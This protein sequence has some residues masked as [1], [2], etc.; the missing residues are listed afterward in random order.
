LAC[1][2]VISYEVVTACGKV[3]NVSATSYPDLFWAL[4][5]GGNNFGIV[6]KFTV[7]AIQKSPLMW[8]GTRLYA[9]P[10]FSALLKAFYNL[11]HNV[12]KD[13]KAHQILS[14]G[15][16]GPQIGYAA[17]VELEYADPNGNAAVLAEYNAIGSQG[18]LQGQT[19]NATLLQ[20]TSAL[21]QSSG[22]NGA[23]QSFITW[24]VGLDLNLANITM[25]ILFEEIPSVINAT[26]ILP[27]LSFQVISEP[28]IQQTFK[29]GG[30]PLG[31]DPKEGPLM[32]VLLN[33][34]WTDIRDDERI[35]AFEMRVKRR[36]EAAALAAGKATD[37]IYMNY[38]NPSQ[39]VISG[40]GATNKAK[41]L[42][43]AKKYDP[44]GVFQKLQPG[45][46][47]LEGAPNDNIKQIN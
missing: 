22:G 33:T 45:Y 19:G 38:G 12:A 39:D 15:Y 1:D 42:A 4:R 5:G 40:Y 36:S 14:F 3:I 13:G 10:A 2:N 31:L 8:G 18:M 34:K 20:L 6:T 21:A 29:N 35:H 7:A 16:G 25:N 11:G 46:F 24:S 30:N 47:K 17:N 37:Y 28:M 32:L 9:Q 27:A 43:I 44:S 41:L 23:R 26:G